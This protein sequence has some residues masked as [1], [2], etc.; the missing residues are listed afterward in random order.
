MGSPGAKEARGDEVP[1]ITAK[2][3]IHPMPLRVDP[4]LPGSDEKEFAGVNP[5]MPAKAGIH[6]GPVDRLPRRGSDIPATRLY[7]EGY[8][9]V[10]HS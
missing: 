3:K 5:V 10:Y 6:P 7:P 8:S 9:A 2:A 4:R 1:V